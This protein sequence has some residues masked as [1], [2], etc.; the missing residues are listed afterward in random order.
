MHINKPKQHG[1][2]FISIL[3]LLVFLGI[4]FLAVLRLLPLYMENMSVTKALDSFVTEYNTTPN[5]QV[6][7]MR[8]AI[9]RRF[10]IDDVTSIT[11]KD[12]LIK[13]NRKGY[14]LDASYKPVAPFLA[15]INFMLDF[16]HAMQLEK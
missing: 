15:N 13:R 8:D 11:A 10:D 4:V 2:S 12:I 16:D 14:A 3:F 7:K 9:Q 5:M 6:N 1:M